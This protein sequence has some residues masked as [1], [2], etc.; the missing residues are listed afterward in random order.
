MF[1]LKIAAAFPLSLC[2][3]GWPLRQQGSGEGKALSG[4]GSAGPSPARSAGT[5]PRRGG[6]GFARRTLVDA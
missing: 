3:G 6:R 2:G 1:G 5:L 4:K